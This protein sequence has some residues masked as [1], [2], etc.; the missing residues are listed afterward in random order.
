[1]FAKQEGYDQAANERLLAN[2]LWPIGLGIAGASQD[3][4][5]QDMQGPVRRFQAKWLVSSDLIQEMVHRRL[6][7]NA[8]FPCL[9]QKIRKTATLHKAHPAMMLSA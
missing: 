2:N 8:G 6:L 3:L 7:S 5:V 4:F 9:R 1:M